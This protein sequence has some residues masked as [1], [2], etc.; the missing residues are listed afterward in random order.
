MTDINFG[1]LFTV[2]ILHNFYAD[3]V[4]PDFSIVTSARTQRVLS[5]HKALARP[6]KNKL[7]AGLQ[8]DAPPPAPLKSFI[9]IE[10]GMQAT[11]FM[12]LNNPLFVNYTNLPFVANLG[13]IYYFTNR[14]NNQVNGKNFLSSKMPA[15][16]NT[17]PYEPGDLVV[18][19]GLVYSAILSNDMA[20]QFDP[21]HA[22]HWMP[23]DNNQY[24]ITNDVLPLFPSVSTWTFATPQ[25]S[26]VIS[27]LGYDDTNFTYTKSVLSKTITFASAYNSFML[28]ISALDPGKYSLTINGVQQWVYINDELSAGGAFAVIDIYNDPAPVS[29]RLVDGSQLLMSPVYSLLF[30]NK[31]T[32]WKYVLTSKAPGTIIDTASKYKF[33]NTANTTTAS[34]FVSLTPIPLSDQL[35]DLTL[36]VNGNTYNPIACADPGRLTNITQSGDIYSCSEI[37][38]NY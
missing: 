11:F 35:L 19:G 18:F 5:G 29:C 22:D 14:N 33:N 26:A 13:Q 12:N 17:M 30:L 1:P 28:N 9:P 10:E 27:V 4:C 37:F 34:T 8:S 16:D 31:A 32:I 21:T 25:T 24:P 23:V 20:H 36:S 38:L 6:Y 15:Y 7:Y 3:Q 2:E